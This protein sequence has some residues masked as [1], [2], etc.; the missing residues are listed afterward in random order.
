MVIVVYLMYQFINLNYMM[1]IGDSKE[2]WASST[3]GHEVTLCSFWREV[4]GYIR[5]GCITLD[6]SMILQLSLLR[7]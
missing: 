3:Y 2:E 6:G 4:S 1:L 5:G 7:N